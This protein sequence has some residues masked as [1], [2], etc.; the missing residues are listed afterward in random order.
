METKSFINTQPALMTMP[1]ELF[2]FCLTHVKSASPY[3]RSTGGSFYTEKGKTWDFTPENCIRISD[4]WNFYSQGQTHCI[5]DVDDRKIIDKWVVAKYNSE[6]KIWEVISADEKDFTA[7][8][9]QKDRIANKNFTDD[10]IKRS[11]TRRER[12]YQ[13]REVIKAKKRAA[14]IKAGKLYIEVNVNV[15]SGSGRRVRFAGTQTLVGKLV[16]ES[17]TGKSFCIK[18]ENGSVRE[19]RAYNSYKELPSLLSNVETQRYF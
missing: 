7:L 17:K 6:T 15:W 19:I 14:K 1:K 5:T 8:Y 10:L 11:Q 16:W 12:A 3:N 4:H 2:Q 13:I 18:T 9:K